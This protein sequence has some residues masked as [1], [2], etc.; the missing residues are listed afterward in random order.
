MWRVPLL[1]VLFLALFTLTLSSLYAYDTRLFGL[2]S[3]TL[4]QSAGAA[5]AGVA[6][7]FP[8][9]EFA[10]GL[11]AIP[12]TFDIWKLPARLADP[13]L[14]P[15]SMAVVEFTSS[16]Q[17]NG[18][19]VLSLENLPLTV[20]VFAFRPDRNTWVTGSGRNVFIGN[21]YYDTA[22]GPLT[23]VTEP[24]APSNIA[25]VFAALSFGNIMVGAGAGYAYDKA[26]DSSTST[27]GTA[28][29]DIDSKATSSVFTIRAGLG[30]DLDAPLP[31]AIDV[32]L[33]VPISKYETT[34]ETGSAA[35]P[36][37]ENDSITADNKSFNLSSRITAGLLPKA[38]VVL[39]VDYASLPQEFTVKDDDVK[40][41]NT[42]LQVD[43]TK[44]TSFGVGAGVNW[45][46]KEGTLL[47]CLL[48]FVSGKAE[49]TSEAAGAGNRP[50]DSTKWTTLEGVI[51]GE[52]QV[53]QKLILRGGVGGSMGWEIE[54]DNQ[55]TGGTDSETTTFTY[56]TS[57][58]AGLGYQITDSVLLDFVVN[59]NNWASTNW[60]QTLS[61]RAAVQV[62]L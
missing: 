24:G 44:V 32:G 30:V 42:T 4:S 8:T 19:L 62:E 55:D 22:T 26:V 11:S 45:K 3:P 12:D 5:A 23:G 33:L 48:T 59:L 47:N 37:N 31:L 43:D 41:T 18:G 52:F 16:T 21:D 9:D 46:P 1:T 50:D 28:N 57:A 29:T 38:D 51:D 14:F 13:E 49:Y 56:G 61:T 25:D 53:S 27:V 39:L 35:V 7:L 15:S 60:L 20:G 10:L 2:N 54:E 17:G 6:V 36:P 40:L 58:A 34:Y